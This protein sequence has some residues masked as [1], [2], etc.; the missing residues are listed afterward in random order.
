MF[1]GMSRWC[2]CVQQVTDGWTCEPEG[3]GSKARVLSHNYRVSSVDGIAGVSSGGETKR[4][5]RRDSSMSS[6][7]LRRRAVEVSVE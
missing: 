7:V 5:R 4:R 2:G 3:R 1:R 6:V